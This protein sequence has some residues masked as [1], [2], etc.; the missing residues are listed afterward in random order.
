MDL[1]QRQVNKLFFHSAHWQ[2]M[3]GIT[4]NYIIWQKQSQTRFNPST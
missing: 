2:S 3:T 4:K 1:N